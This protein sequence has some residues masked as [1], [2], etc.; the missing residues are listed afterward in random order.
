MIH[1]IRFKLILCLL[2]V[3]FLVGGVS[4]FIGSQLLYN[5]MTH[6]AGKHSRLALNATHDVYD[7][8]IKFIKTALDIT[9]LGS[10]FHSSMVN[11]DLS[12][13]EFRINRLAGNAELD[14]A[15]IVTG[16]GVL[17]SR[18]SPFS[19]QDKISLQKN[20]LVRQAIRQG[21]IISGTIVLSQNFMILENPGLAKRLQNKPGNEPGQKTTKAD[22]QTTCMA[23]AAAVPIFETPGKEKLAGVLYGGILL[24]QSTSIVDSIPKSIFF[25]NIQSASNTLAVNIFFNNFCI[26]TNRVDQ[27]GKRNFGARAP[28]NVRH[29]VMIRGDQWTSRQ[30]DSTGQN[31]VSYDPIYDIFGKRVG[32]LSIAISESNYLSLQRKFILYLSLAIFASVIIAIAM[33]IF[34]THRI[35]HPIH[36]LIRASLEVSNG[37]VSPDLGLMSKDKEMAV[38]Q[39]TFG[40]MV[41]SVKR[42]RMESRTQ[43]IQ[44]EKQASIGRL[45]AGV[46]HEINNPLTGVLTYT[47]ML[48]RRKDIPDDVRSDLHVIAESTERVRKIVKGLLDFSRQTRLNP[49]RIDINQLASSTLKLMENQALLKGVS[50]QFKPGKNIPMMVIDRNKTESVLLNIL[51]NALDS[52]KAGDTITL[53]TTTGVST[54]NVGHRGVEIVITDT[55]CGILPENLNKL[56]D[57]FFTTK[58]VG[59]GTG[60]GLSVSYGIVKEHGGTIRV[61]SEIGEGSTFFIWLPLKQQN[62]EKQNQEKLGQ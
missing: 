19:T 14:F 20:P 27:N 24:H 1:S 53:Q 48:L 44:S 43:I 57:P 30:N 41:E 59:S 58:E 33:G 45:A 34:L 28:D 54:D 49:E 12:D 35:M 62:Q 25:D 4:L 37:N 16:V 18:L 17:L 10:G 2:I 11:K 47:H 46:G 60:L 21:R 7:A 36:R 39:T 15:G 32:I 9:T 31:L 42:R 61:Q 56:F 51:I 38:L 29:Q 40:W 13:L 55:G 50:I 26:A 5:A 52:T 6:E 3:S 8:H 23:I 22:E